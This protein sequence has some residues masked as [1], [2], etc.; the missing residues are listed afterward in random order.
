[1]PDTFGDAMRRRFLLSEKK[2]DVGRSNA[3]RPPVLRGLEY[4]LCITARTTSLCICQ[5]DI[6]TTLLMM[7][8]EGAK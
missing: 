5:V 1:M 7:S 6:F 8:V 4:S 3:P 2:T